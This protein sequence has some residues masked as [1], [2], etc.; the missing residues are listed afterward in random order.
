MD[1]VQGTIT[2]W[3]L[4]PILLSAPPPPN[5]CFT[6]CGCRVC[7][8][9]PSSITGPVFDSLS[10]LHSATSAAVRGPWVTLESSCPSAGK[11]LTSAE[12]K[13]SSVDF[14]PFSGPVYC[15]SWS[16]SLQSSDRVGQE[17]RSGG[18]SPPLSLRPPSVL[19]GAPLVCGVVGSPR[20]SFCGSS[21]SF[22]PV[23]SGQQPSRQVSAV[24]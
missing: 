3:R 11:R 16:G 14:C 21:K 13:N 22:L 1:D 24:T 4:R 5:R 10:T 7:Q 19:A 6:P 15:A 23:F 8:L 9:C 2:K 12:G 20:T 18:V 17:L